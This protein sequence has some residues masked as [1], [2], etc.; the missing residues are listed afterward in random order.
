MNPT[1]K[2]FLTFL[3]GNLADISANDQIGRFNTKGVYWR[4]MYLPWAAREQLSFILFVVAL[5]RR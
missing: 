3:A 5:P 2:V 4:E 1:Y